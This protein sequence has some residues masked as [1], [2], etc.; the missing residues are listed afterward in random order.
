MSE[1]RSEELSLAH[2][3]QDPAGLV[4][5][6]HFRYPISTSLRRF[7]NQEMCRLNYKT[8]RLRAALVR[9]SYVLVQDGN[10]QW[11]WK[12]IQRELVMYKI[13]RIITFPSLKVGSCNGSCRV[14]C[15]LNE[16]LPRHPDLP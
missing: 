13:F 6:H 12:G 9:W 14:H 1:H 15:C 3:F 16:R 8:S 2:D 11:W 7:D 4:L 10:K 5:V